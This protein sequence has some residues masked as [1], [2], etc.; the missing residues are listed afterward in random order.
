MLQDDEFYSGHF[1]G[2]LRILIRT[3]TGNNHL[4][5]RVLLTE[6]L[7]P[8]TEM[9]VQAHTPDCSNLAEEHPI[10]VDLFQVAGDDRTLEFE[11]DL[12]G[13]GHAAGRRC[14]R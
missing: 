7:Y 1:P 2:G 13:R 11:L 3:E 6:M 4:I 10:N 14:K 8:G 12:P 9:L 5:V